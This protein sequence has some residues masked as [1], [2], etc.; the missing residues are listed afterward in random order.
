MTQPHHRVAVITGAARPQGRSHAL[1]LAGLGFD[2]IAID[3]C[4]DIPSARYPLATEADLD[5]TADLVLDAG[6]RIETIVADVRDLP[7]LRAGIATGTDRF[8]D[9][10]ILIADAGVIDHGL[11]D[12]DDD[13]LYRDIVDINLTGAWHTIAATAPSMM[14][15]G[16]G[17]SITLVSY[18]QNLLGRDN[19]VSAASAAYAASAHGVVGLTRSASSAYGPHGIRVNAVLPAEVPG[20]RFF[21]KDTKD[22]DEIELYTGYLSTAAPSS[23]CIDPADVT[24]AVL[25][26]SSDFARHIS[27]MAL[28]IGAGFAMT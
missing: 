3:C 10:D 28:A 22:L 4:S 6:G 23:R 9:V 16:T 2:I 8:G 12:S 14:R 7:G 21:S 20:T 17:G 25:F 24:D 18:M 5:R 13:Q 15:L 27:G 11:T 26:L 19:D 1:A